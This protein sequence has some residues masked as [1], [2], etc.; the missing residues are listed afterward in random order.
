M[1]P[2][3]KLLMVQGGSDPGEGGALEGERGAEGRQL[4]AILREGTLGSCCGSAWV[5]RLR[6]LI[7]ITGAAWG[8]NG[9]GNGERRGSLQ[10]RLAKAP[11]SVEMTGLLAGRDAD[12][13]AGAR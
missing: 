1:M 13:L 5:G 6:L 3:P 11:P 7:V 12:L 9:E 10:E 8:R 4:S 2:N